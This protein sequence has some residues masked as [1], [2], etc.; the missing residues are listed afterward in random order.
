M[1]R[2][3]LVPPGKR[4]AL[5]DGSP[6]TDWRLSLRRRWLCSSV[7]GCRLAGWR[8]AASSEPPAASGPEPA[9]GAAGGP[10]GAGAGRCLVVQLLHFD[11]SSDS[12]RE[13]G[14]AR[15]ETRSLVLLDERG[16]EWG[17]HH[18]MEEEE[19]G[20]RDRKELVGGRRW[21]EEEQ[22]DERKEEECGVVLGGGLKGSERAEVNWG[23][24]MEEQRD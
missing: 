5:Q 19:G 23:D 22:K 14:G 20:N 7:S 16:E 12:H 17:S 11:H 21:R 1:R 2:E 10:D 18:A 24:G 9:G 3:E 13:D 4:A 15:G 8:T 6:R